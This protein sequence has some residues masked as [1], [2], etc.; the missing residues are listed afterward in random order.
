MEQTSGSSTR[1]E[2]GGGGGGG[3]GGVGSGNNKVGKKSDDE[4]EEARTV[5]RKDGDGGDGNRD[6][7]DSTPLRMRIA[8]KL[9][10]SRLRWSRGHLHGRRDV[11]TEAKAQAQLHVEVDVGVDLGLG[12]TQRKE[13]TLPEPT[14]TPASSTTTIISINTNSFGNLNQLVLSSTPPSSPAESGPSFSTTTRSSTTRTSEVVP[15]TTVTSFV[16]APVVTVWNSTAIRTSWHTTRTTVERTVVVIASPTIVS[17]RRTSTRRSSSTRHS[18]STSHRP[19]ASSSSNSTSA[20]SSRWSSSTVLPT[21]YSTYGG[22]GGGGGGGATALPTSSPVP[23]NSVSASSGPNVNPTLVGG[24]LGGLCAFA[25]VLVAILFALRRHKRRL[26]EQALDDAG[27]GGPLPTPAGS[28]GITERS[29]V[30]PFA[31]AASLFGRRSRH[32]RQQSAASEPTSEQGFYRVGGR[33]I[34]PVL[35]GPRPAGKSLEGGQSF[36]DEGEGGHVRSPPTPISAGAG[37]SRFSSHTATSTSP[38]ISSVPGPT[39]PMA[40]AIPATARIP[41]EKDEGELYRESTPTGSV[42][43]PTPTPEFM[44]RPQLAGAAGRDGLGRS[45]PSHDGSRASKFTEDIV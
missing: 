40:A 41:E 42:R 12:N 27:Y 14:P 36:F 32:S 26:A 16:S 8:R 24:V 5:V 39:V 38:I 22:G 31:A 44:T 1:D 18:S 10:S 13:R 17:Y 25:L 35:G 21:A 19:S 29:S 45:L 20:T 34:D 9:R 23:T 43:R 3:G 28:R 7:L 15:V 37:P 2:G 11:T 33:K 30:T 6:L 4:E